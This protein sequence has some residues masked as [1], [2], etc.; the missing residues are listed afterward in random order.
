MARLLTPEE[1]GVFAI[2][3]AASHI[4]IAF[5]NFGIGSYLVREKEI[6]RSKKDTAFTL[7]LCFSWSAAL[8]LILIKDWLATVYGAPPI[9]DVMTLLAFSFLITPFG[10]T[11]YSLLTRAMRFDV[12]HH[13]NLFALCTG[14]ATSIILAWLGHSYM[15]LAWGFLAENLT[16]A[17][18][19]M[20]INRKEFS[21]HLSLAH[22]RSV[23]RFGGYLT[24][25]SLAGELNRQSVKFVLGGLI[26]PTSV[27]LYE[28]A[29]QIPVLVRR[30]IFT[31][32]RAVLF[33][34]FSEDIRNGKSIGQG[35][36]QVVAM[37]T[38]LVIPV[39]L[40]VALCSEA[41][42]VLLFGENWRIA[43][44]LL[45]WFLLS[46]AI[47]TLLP[48][49]EQV[50][51]PH[52]RVKRLFK[53]RL[54]GLISNLIVAFIGASQSLELFAALRPLQTIIFFTLTYWSIRD[55]WD[56]R[57][58]KLFPAY[59]QAVVIAA[60]SAL[61]AVISFYYY[62]SDPPIQS[63]LLITIASTLIWPIAV[64]YVGHPI[65]E[66]IERIRLA[67]VRYS[68]T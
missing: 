68:T 33:P 10:Q 39:F 27:A 4:L 50:L 35:V 19:L 59:S 47:L 43:G 22:W 53:L 7:W 3:M 64:Y 30:S 42:V 37:T 62:G 15:S 45:P 21:L 16:R 24:G 25:S 51:T 61:P 8:I 18:V 23:M 26:S 66:E 17:L 44:T 29:I 55:F 49:P 34:K 5:R 13:I 58:I 9:S 54:L 63:L 52:G 40:V 14:L 67:I 31:P 56:T 65:K 12:L 11:H 2:S 1:F 28:R 46:N 32:L 48:Q 60:A 41:L 57:L 36:E 38:V 6:T 20:A